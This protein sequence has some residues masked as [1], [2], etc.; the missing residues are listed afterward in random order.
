MESTD[1]PEIPDKGGTSDAAGL[2]F[3][4]YFV[5]VFRR[6]CYSCS[7]HDG[8]KQCF[9]TVGGTR[10]WEDGMSGLTPALIFND[11]CASPPPPF[12]FF[13]PVPYCWVAL[14]CMFSLMKCD[15]QVIKT[16]L[17][18]FCMH[19][20]LFA[21]QLSLIHLINVV[22]NKNISTAPSFILQ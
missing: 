17:S 8:S 1:S 6:W 10:S 9:C 4:L 14:A 21:V 13:P 18:S 3:E 7:K 19:Q 16:T 15:F 12:H 2:P 11:L 20:V 22:I 5:L